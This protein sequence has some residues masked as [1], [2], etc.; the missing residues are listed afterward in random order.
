LLGNEGEFIDKLKDT[1]NFFTH[2]GIERKPTVLLDPLELYTFN[3]RLHAF[4]RLLV[5]MYVGFDEKVVFEPTFSQV[6][7][8]P[9]L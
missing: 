2:P 9:N 3:Q 1:R 5:L 6:P 8:G 7:K 4:L